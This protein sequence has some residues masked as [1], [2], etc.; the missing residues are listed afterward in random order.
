MADTSMLFTTVKNPLVGAHVYGYLG[1]HGRTLLGGAHFS[2]IGSLVDYAAGGKPTRKRW[3]DAIQRD[4]LAV[5][6]RIV[7]ISTPRPIL[8]DAISGAIKALDLSGGALGVVDPSWGP[9]IDV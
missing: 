4:L 9:Y 2:Q 1:Y 7:I 5:P 3:T 6:Q 8:K